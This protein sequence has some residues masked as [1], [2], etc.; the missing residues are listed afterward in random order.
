MRPRLL[1]TL[2]FA[3]TSG[4][5]A[6]GGSTDE[7]DGEVIAVI[8]KGTNHEFWKSIHA[9]ACKAASETDS[10]IEWMG[11][12]KEDDREAQ[13]TMVENFISAGAKGIVL[14]PMD[15]RALV[16]VC[17]EAVEE[18]IPVVIIDSGLDW[19]GYVSFVASDNYA[20]GVK[21][22]EHLGLLLEGEGDVILLRYQVGSASTTRREEG[23]LDAMRDKFPQ[24]KLLDTDQR[25][26]ATT[27]SAQDKAEALLQIFKEE[28][29]GIFCPNESTVHGM[30][31]ALEDAGMAG[32]VRFV[33]F[34]A[35]D[36]LA[37]ALRDGK[38]DGLILQDPFA[39]GEKGVQAILDHQ[40]G[41][42]VPK[43]IDTGVYLATPENMDEPN[44]QRLLH[45]D[46]DR[47]L[48]D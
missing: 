2:L 18:G 3:M 22:A 36:M 40:A 25:A 27:G 28:V 9:G 5:V 1:G 15:D 38:I 23:F 33:G 35:T 32:Q 44:I 16:S 30:L 7:D 45:P 20:G 46:L 37:E 42:T 6:C 11:P 24:V 31:R 12:E 17:E 21:A 43:R 13:K 34:D 10:S 19:D 29:D 39:M 8:P 47:W 4:L 41:K 48:G 26:G 14:A